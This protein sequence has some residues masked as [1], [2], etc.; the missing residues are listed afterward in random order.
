MIK[1]KFMDNEKFYK[2]I[3]EIREVVSDPEK[4]KCICPNTFCEWHGK[5]REC[6]AQHRHYGKH[7][8]TCLQPILKEKISALAQAA[9]LSVEEMERSS[10]EHWEYVHKKDAEKRTE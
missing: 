9:E 7:I 5:C 2:V 6:V 3:Q 10:V 1:S 8:P 4:L